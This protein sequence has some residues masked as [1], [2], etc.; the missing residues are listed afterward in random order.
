MGLTDADGN[1]FLIHIGIDTVKLNGQG[2]TVH[3]KQGDAVK[4]GDLLVEF[5]KDEIEKAGYD[6]TVIYILTDA[7]KKIEIAE[8]RHEA[9]SDTVIRAM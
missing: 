8:G 4:K 5:D 7:D 1:E 9:L 3:V 2:F 6:S